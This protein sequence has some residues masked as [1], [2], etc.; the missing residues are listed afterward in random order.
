MLDHLSSHY[1]QKSWSDMVNMVKK[2]GQK[3][4]KI[5][6]LLR[7]QQQQRNDSRKQCQHQNSDN[8]IEGILSSNINNKVSD[9]AI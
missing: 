6:K 4:L 2:D 5:L 9:C 8:F 3:Y 7:E 1:G